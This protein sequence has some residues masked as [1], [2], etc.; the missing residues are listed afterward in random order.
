MVTATRK[1]L[2]GYAI[3]EIQDNNIEYVKGVYNPRPL[4]L[5]AVWKLLL[6]FNT[7]GCHR[8]SYPL[9]FSVKCN[10]LDTTKLSPMH[11]GAKTPCVVWNRKQIVEHL[12]GQH[13]MAVVGT[14]LHKL[15]HDIMV[16]KMKGEKV[17]KVKLVAA[18]E[19]T[20]KEYE[21]CKKLLKVEQLLTNM[22][23]GCFYNKGKQPPKI[24]RNM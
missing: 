12:G 21:D 1:A 23:I 18:G 17:A 10:Q 6:E 5:Q 19:M 9:I 8:Y 13:C 16:M 20:V 7:V 4:N 2:L 14:K 24:G 11:E 22:W 15:N 3:V